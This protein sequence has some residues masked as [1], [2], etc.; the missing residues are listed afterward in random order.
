MS[1]D[2]PK[3][4]SGQNPNSSSPEVVGRKNF[5][6]DPVVED[7]REDKDP[8]KL[9]EK[10]KELE[11]PAPDLE[12]KPKSEEK[13]KRPPD[14]ASPPQELSKNTVDDSIVESTAQS[15]PNMTLDNPAA[16]LIKDKTYNLPVHRSAN[17]TMLKVI[18]IVCFVAC[19]VAGSVYV[20]VF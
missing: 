14:T 8:P 18:L 19:V 17:K 16:K 7:N 11:V 13:S 6:Q 12:D 15:Q 10:H 3:D 1:D 4:I 2:K 9:H 20:I 5:I